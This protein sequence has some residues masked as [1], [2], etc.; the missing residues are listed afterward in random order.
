MFE[1]LKIVLNGVSDSERLFKKELEKS[2]NWLNPSEQ[3]IF[4]DWVKNR[5]YE[6]YPEII[7]KAFSSTKLN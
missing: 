4:K 6:K 2:L 1:H 5:Y 7:E 3:S